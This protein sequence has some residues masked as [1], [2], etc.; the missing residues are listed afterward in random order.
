MPATPRGT[1]SGTLT[2]SCSS[3]G[4]RGPLQLEWKPPQ[5]SHRPQVAA[6]VAE[7]GI[8]RPDEIDVALEVFDAYCDAPGRDY[9]ACAAF[10]GPDE[11]AGFAFYGPT[12]CTVDTWDL[13][14]IAV[15]PRFQRAG[16][17]RSL[18]QQVEHHICS[19]GARMCVIETSSRDD[20]AETRD[21]YLA[22]GY[23][24]V[25][26]IPG[27]YADDDDRVTYAKYFAGS[28]CLRKENESREVRTKG[29][30]EGCG[31]E[32]PLTSPNS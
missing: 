10:A 25:A 32:L 16:I 19:S 23:E 6:V 8:F 18:L 11:L 1:R 30:G 2:P 28:L 17:G 3:A 22:C 4:R 12:P 5:R 21:F 29:H 9:W 26:R 14:W 20:Y 27:F 13:Y 24:E 7:T 15:H 31:T